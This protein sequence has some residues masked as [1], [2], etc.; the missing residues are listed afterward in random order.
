MR[1]APPLKRAPNLARLSFEAA[2]V[3]ARL[4]RVYPSSRSSC[5]FNSRLALPADGTLTLLTPV[6]KERERESAHFLRELQD[7]HLRPLSMHNRKSQP[8]EQKQTDFYTRSQ[9]PTNFK[10][11]K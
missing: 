6:M 5:C 10:T 3:T 4:C 2:A 1:S 7:A 8:K 9:R 11:N